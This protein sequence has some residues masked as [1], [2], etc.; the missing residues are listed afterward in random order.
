MHCRACTHARPLRVAAADPFGPLLL[1]PDVDTPPSSQ[2]DLFGEFLNSDAPAAQPAPFPSTHSAP[3][4]ACSTDFLHLGEGSLC[5]WVWGGRA[6]S[7]VLPP[8]GRVRSRCPHCAPCWVHG[9]GGR[10]GGVCVW[11][12]AAGGGPWRT[13]QVRNQT[14]VSAP[15][16]ESPLAG[17]S[18]PVLSLREPVRGRP[19]GREPG[20]PL[21]GRPSRGWG[22]PADGTHSQ[23]VPGALRAHVRLCVHP[24]GDPQKAPLSS[25]GTCPPSPAR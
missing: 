10:F 2:P 9:V 22:C 15:P 25:Q 13:S 3:P 17:S 11:L 8:P 7:Q 14:L 1:P 18:R 24:T 20:G 5:S 16:S 23:A 6:W 21:P 19:G 4:P 12:A